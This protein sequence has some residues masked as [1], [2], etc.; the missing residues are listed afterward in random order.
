MSFQVT[1]EAHSA[2]G[3]LLQDDAAAVTASFN[4]AVSIG[5]SVEASGRYRLD[6]K[7]VVDVGSGDNNTTLGNGAQVSDPT[8]NGQISIQAGPV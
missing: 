1:P 4:E 2:T 6:S 7:V 8:A 5:R 3:D